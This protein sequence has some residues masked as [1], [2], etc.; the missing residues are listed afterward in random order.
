MIETYSPYMTP[1]QK[2]D[3]QTQL[4]GLVSGFENDPVVSSY[5]R[6]IG[7]AMADMDDTVRKNPGIGYNRS[8]SL[9]HG[10]SAIK[11]ILKCIEI[12]VSTYNSQVEITTGFDQG[13]DDKVSLVSD[14]SQ[15]QGVGLAEILYN[16]EL[17]QSHKL[18]LSPGED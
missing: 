5:R 18:E 11:T 4:D 9:T 1:E 16:T 14:K 2:K 17:T 3:F 15:T 8:A 7:S 13:S 10:K 6:L 12:Y